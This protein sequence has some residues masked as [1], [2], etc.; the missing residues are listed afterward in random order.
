MFSAL[1]ALGAVLAL[2][3][4]KGNDALSTAPRAA[5]SGALSV[6]HLQAGFR[7]RFRPIA[8]H[9]RLNMLS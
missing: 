7:N 4:Q 3:K 9:V 8:F 1:H 5:Q 6:N 2:G